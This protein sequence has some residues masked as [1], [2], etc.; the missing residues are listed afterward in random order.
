MREGL[1]KRK[2]KKNCTPDEEQAPPTHSPQCVKN[3]GELI[4]P[5]L[6][7]IGTTPPIAPTSAPHAG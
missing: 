5:L 6:D 2:K 7:Y 1:K 4:Q 3:S